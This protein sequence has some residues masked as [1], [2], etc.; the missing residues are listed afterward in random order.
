MNDSH[1]DTPR[2]RGAGE[3]SKDPSLVTSDE[4]AVPPPPAEE[5]A[6]VISQSDAAR[7][8]VTEIHQLSEQYRDCVPHPDTRAAYLLRYRDALETVG[9]EAAAAVIAGCA[10][11]NKPWGPA[12]LALAERV[13]ARGGRP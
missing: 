8:T 11:L 3:R 10:T 12:L 13:R 7:L 5:E 4:T 9:D 2:S 6:V 1:I